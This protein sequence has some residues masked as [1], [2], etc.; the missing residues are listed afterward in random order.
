MKPLPRLLLLSLLALLP[1][2][3]SESALDVA[4]KNAE[5]ALGR[6]EAKE[7][8]SWLD[9]AFERDA[10][11][12]RAWDLRAKSAE[13]AGDKDGQVRALHQLLRLAVAQ[14]RPPSE[15]EG[16]RARILAVDPVAKDLFD[17]TQ[18]F[19]PKLKAVAE[20][21][22]KDKRPHSAI[23][24]YKE[25]LAL[26][27]E[28]TSSHDAIQRLAATPDPS[29]AG[30]AKPK[31]LLAGVSEEW[32]RERDLQHDTWEKRDKIEREHYTTM[33]DTG[34][35]NLVRASEAMEQ[36][37]AFYREFFHYGTPEDGHQVPK[38]E[39]R[40]FK[41]HDE[42]MKKGSSPKDW[43]GGQFTGDSVE[44]YIGDAGFNDMTQTL[45]HEASHQFVGM[46]TGAS[47][48]LNEGL[49]S[50]FEGTRM[51]SNGTVIMNL[52]A[53][54]R[55]FDLV[56]RLKEGWMA[57]E[58]DGIDPSNKSKSEPKKAPTF[59][60]VLED[61]Y[62][63]GP[64]WY[65]PT[66]AVVYFLYNYQDPID[67]RYVYRTAFHEFIN[68]SG[69]R[70]GKGAVK[71]FEEVVLAKPEPPIK[72][73][74]RPKGSADVRLPKNVA[75]LDPVWKDWLLDLAKEQNGESE[76][77]RPYLQW[78]RNALKAKNDAIAREHFEK[79]LLA[80]PQDI[81][82]LLEFG[83]FLFERKSG[84]RASKLALEALRVLE[85]KTPPDDAALRNAERALEKWDPKQ[86][87]LEAV[88]EEL[89]AAARRVVQEYQDANMPTM[90]MD[91]AWHL[92]ADL[93][94][95]GMFAAY[96]RALRQGGHSLDLWKLAYNEKN[97]D[98]WAAGTDGVF[99]A[100]GE[101]LDAKFGAY[102]EKLF[103][104]RVLTLDTVTSGDWSLEAQVQAGKGECN[105][106]GLAFGKK[107]LQNFHAL[108]L[109]PGRTE[110]S[111][112]REGLAESGFVDLASCFGNASFKTWRHNPVKASP[113][114]KESGTTTAGAPWHKV[115]IDVADNLV[116]T[117][118]DGEF[119]ATQEFPSSDPL[120][121]N[122]G[123]IVGPGTA[124][125]RNIRFLARPARDPAAKID[126]AVR[127]E[128]IEA[129][130]GPPPGGSYLGRVPPFP[131]VEKWVQGSRKD[132]K[133]K[134]PVP[135][136]LVL[137]S[138]QQNDLVRIDEW[139]RDLADKRASIGLEIVAIA[140]PNDSENLAGY[141]ASHPMPG[142]VGV[143]KREKQGIGDTFEQF[144]IEKFNLPRLILIDIDGKVA[145]EG[146]PG[147]TRGEPWEAGRESYFDTP[148]SDLVEKDQLEALGA[149]LAKWKATGADAVAKGNVEAAVPILREAKTLP[150]GRVPAVDDARRKLAAI[151]SALDGLSATVADFVH[152]GV[153]PALPLLADMGKAMKKTLDRN[154]LAAL[155]KTRDG[156]ANKEWAE[157]LQRCERVV[158][159]AKKEDKLAQAQDLVQRLGA[160]EGKF[161]KDLLAD[162]SPALE[163][164][165]VP[166]M[167]EIASKAPER[168]RQWLLREYLR[169]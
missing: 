146:D 118:F 143:D 7:A 99:K 62:E 28:S 100:N 112:S 63:W 90:V 116:D 74:V 26:D 144:S 87:S 57:N 24:A 58:S 83:A 93:N 140:S 48:W 46:A 86:K 31:D 126:R 79:A 106:C 40:I 115:R 125:F 3:A 98:G 11:S 77:K 10:K 167:V 54:G 131:Y 39:L 130:A 120:R 157:V 66:W 15:I 156:K 111:G 123:L 88:H 128:K 136:L 34:Y 67:G 114:T 168:P 117:W 56:P 166:K 49:A 72:G 94:V 104:F 122:F 89:W 81:D 121:G 153:D 80:A 109:F 129:N 53:N 85:S 82:T 127:M 23:R 60:I 145:W 91:L 65:A 42:Y 21:Y 44:T 154:G 51:L 138:I 97:L 141:L 107:G 159:F 19:V 30:D 137:W 29:L 68:A 36:L 27:P 96:E 33:T 64:P 1:S 110:A 134:G 75:E 162:F 149:W 25:I 69:G 105:F 59:K 135:Q 5:A 4:L 38:L 50:F 151:E 6:K 16:L 169:W 124:A 78:A 20:Q 165:D 103:D 84:D 71:N 41:N 43:S 119:L 101:T 142:A 102:D 155:A 163:Q 14:K 2:G 132:W 35:A 147:F 22:E 139:L 17:L 150:E 113:A 161:P 152:D 164:S 70:A 47:G 8:D 73:V 160:M 37:N 61:K 52:P 133:E 108:I 9:R 13:A 12:L 18:T 158:K 32:I 148:L 95:P 55:L 45:F 76:V 92:G